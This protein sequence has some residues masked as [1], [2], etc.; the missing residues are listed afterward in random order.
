[1][2]TSRIQ[3][4]ISRWLEPRRQHRARQ[5]QRAMTRHDRDF[6]VRRIMRLMT[7]AGPPESAVSQRCRRGRTAI[8]T[9]YAF[10]GFSPT[11]W[12][13]H[14]LIRPRVTVTVWRSFWYSRT[15]TVPALQSAV[16]SPR[17]VCRGADRKVRRV[18]I[19]KF[20]ERKRACRDCG[21]LPFRLRHQRSTRPD[22]VR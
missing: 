9:I 18:K 8:H 4:H 2:R 16:Y 6:F 15:R 20:V 22:L 17:T 5:N 11:R 19:A 14:T 12:M 10:G 1:V 21:P 3:R 13:S 7:R